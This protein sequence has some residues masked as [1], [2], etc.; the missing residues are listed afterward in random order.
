[1]RFL[2]LYL[3]VCLTITSCSSKQEPGIY[4]F[5][6]VSF[7]LNQG[8]EIATI[9][10]TKKAIFNS[11]F[12]NKAIQI[13]L[14]RCIKSDNYLIFIG[15]PFNTSIKKLSDYNFTTTSKQTFFESDKTNYFFKKFAGEKEQATIYTRNFSKNL[16]FILT[17]S[18]SS[19][20]SDSLFNINV[21]SSRFKIKP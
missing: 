9:D 8:E 12:N 15:I 4:L 10:P 6:E 16:V 13:P 14:Y 21:L 19:K 7:N 20:L 5:N 18:D 11:Y 1:M 17:I 3:L 2:I